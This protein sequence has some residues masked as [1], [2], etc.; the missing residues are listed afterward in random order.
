M[1]AL[2]AWAYAPALHGAWLWDD[3]ATISENPLL[4]T[5]RGLGDLWLGRGT[6]DY[7][8]LSGTV[9]WLEWHAFGQSTLG[10]HVV[11]LALHGLS[12]LGLT[13]VLRRLGIRSAWIGGA[14]FALHPLAVE[15]VAWIS[16]LKN[17]LSASVLFPAVLA[18]LASEDL[19]AA[20]R[21]ARG[22]ARPPGALGLT[23]LG[24]KWSYAFSLML[25]AA[26]ALA[27]SSMRYYIVPPIRELRKYKIR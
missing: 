4:R 2:A 23:A 9:A 14:L 19:A 18:Y 7:F 8:P 11:A 12:A 25:Y 6:P 22:G 17:V 20:R 27:K 5:A 1:A 26:S 16:E 10:Y 21:M 3:A 15:S 24:P 13:A